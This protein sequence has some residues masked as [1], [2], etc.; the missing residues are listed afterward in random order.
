MERL[1]SFA[2]WRNCNICPSLWAN[3]GFYYTGERNL[4]CC[5]ACNMLMPAETLQPPQGAH[6]PICSFGLPNNMTVKEERMKTFEKWPEWYYPRPM[7]LAEVGLYFTGVGDRVKCAYCNGVLQ[8]WEQNDNPA[9][10]H[11]KFYKNCPAVR[12]YDIPPEYRQ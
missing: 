11:K 9:Q 5:M 4:V 7:E 1:S 2:S 12:G 8:H 10:E 3:A 6:E